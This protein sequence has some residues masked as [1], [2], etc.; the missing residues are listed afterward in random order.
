MKR[1]I[2]LLLSLFLLCC[3]ACS[4]DPSDNRIES[5]TAPARESAS[6]LSDDAEENA[7]NDAAAVPDTD[8]AAPSSSL[9]SGTNETQDNAGSDLSAAPGA[10][11]SDSSS[12]AADSRTVYVS[13]S[14]KIH[15]IPDCSGMKHYTE[16]TYRE[17]VSA[18]YVE[19]KNCY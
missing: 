17:A 15:A 19:C 1:H 5:N 2:A 16:M 3:S 11:G 7:E 18:G 14:G 8:G 10:S 6:L 9:I 12:S 13:N 4:S